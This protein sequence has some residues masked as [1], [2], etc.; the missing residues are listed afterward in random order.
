MS[1]RAWRVVVA[2]FVGNAFGSTV[3]VLFTLGVFTKPLEDDLGFSRAQVSSVAAIYTLVGTLAF[4]AAGV[5]LDR[6]GARRVV[7]VSVPLFSAAY[8][9]LSFVPP[10]ISVFYLTWIAITMVGAGSTPAPY[11][12]AVAASFDRRLGLAM[13]VAVAG[14]GVGAAM[15]PAMAHALI[16][17]IGWR[18]AYVA[19][20][21]VTLAI[22]STV[23]GV[24]LRPAVHRDGRPLAM[25][26]DFRV[27]ARSRSFTLIG[28]AFFLLG[29]M[30][31]AVL[32]HQVPMLVDDG[33]TPKDAALVQVVYGIAL[34]I[35]R[36]VVGFALDR[37]PATRV[38]IVTLG[39]VL[40]GI[41][42]YAMGAHGRAAFL[43]ATLIGFGVGAEMDVLG[44]LIARTFGSQA[45]GKLSAIVLSLFTLGGGLG[46]TT[47]GAIRTAYGNYAPGL[48]LLVV[49][50]MGAIAFLARLDRI[51]SRGSEGAKL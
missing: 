1:S 41:T 30:S 3:L 18:A 16:T 15:L 20:A 2:A 23:N 12:K 36:V 40:I 7:L 13:G 39:G 38:L 37:F 8:A 24:F 22:T 14:Q 35:G 27:A 45:F 9:T 47:L 43:C 48:W 26:D 32:S 46:A 19:L 5:L 28:A 49:A 50:T 44:Y 11:C 10:R 25:R 31:T 33:A 4:P 29:F 6:F 21:G 42:A 51:T 17:H 34:T